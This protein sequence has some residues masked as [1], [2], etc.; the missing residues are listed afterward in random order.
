MIDI[1]IIGIAAGV[2]GI[3]VA[4]AVKA[5]SLLKLGIYSTRIET[6]THTPNKKK[7]VCPM[8]KKQ[9]KIRLCIVC[10]YIY[11]YMHNKIKFSTTAINGYMNYKSINSTIK[12]SQ[13][14]YDL[15]YLSQ[16]NY[17]PPYSWLNHVRSSEVLSVN[18]HF[19]RFVNVLFDS[20]MF[21]DQLQV[22]VGKYS[23]H[24]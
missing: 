13:T 21:E 20:R 15:T 7:R 9:Q 19:L 5:A 2:N 22:P 14:M 24:S 10:V 11:T 1:V 8:N 4:A 18:H 23:P 17:K 16:I 12:V 3:F 6:H